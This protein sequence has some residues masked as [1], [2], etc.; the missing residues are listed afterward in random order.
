MTDRIKGFVVTLESDVRIDD[1]K[2]I[3]T[4]IS[5]IKGVINVEPSIA[6]VDDQIN[7]ARIKHE[8]SQKILNALK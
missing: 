8:L 7:Q 2:A 5:M 6:G 1:V 3:M 4:S